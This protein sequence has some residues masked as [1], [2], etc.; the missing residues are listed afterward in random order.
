MSANQV[1]DII[2]L[3]RRTARNIGQALADIAEELIARQQHRQNQL[4]PV[5]E[6]IPVRNSGPSSTNPFLNRNGSGSRRNFSTF[7]NSTK[8]SA[9]NNLKSTKFLNL[10]KIFFSN[11]FLYGSNLRNSMNIRNFTTNSNV[12]SL[13]S[14]ARNFQKFPKIT[15]NVRNVMWNVSPFRTSTRTCFIANGSGGPGSFLYKNFVRHN[16]RLFSTYGPSFT[17]QAAN[18]LTNGVRAMIYNTY[19]DLKKGKKLYHTKNIG[20]MN[21]SKRHVSENYRLASTN[22][23]IDSKLLPSAN[24]ENDFVNTGCVVEFSLNP[25]TSS[26]CQFPTIAILDDDVMEDLENIFINHRQLVIKEIKLI[27]ENLGETIIE[28]FTNENGEPC[29]RLRFPNCDVEKMETLLLDLGVS[30]GVV[31]PDEDNDNQLKQLEQLE[32]MKQEEI[33][34]NLVENNE[35]LSSTHVSTVENSSGS[36]TNYHSILSSSNY[37]NVETNDRDEWFEINSNISVPDLVSDDNHHH[38]HSHEN[39]SNH[40][41]SDHNNE[42]DNI[43]SSEMN[44]ILSSSFSENESDSTDYNSS[45]NEIDYFQ[46]LSSGSE[47]ENEIDFNI[48]ISNDLYQYEFDNTMNVNNDLFEHY[49]NLA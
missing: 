17:H 47:N 36:E 7:T 35:I 26:N 30:L 39:E 42:N 27:K 38:H 37:A 46:V 11:K 40:I 18:N 6:R 12:S 31:K 13:K 24:V 10:F 9:R 22:S 25:S 4:Q 16:Q 28:T 29:I 45:F 3:S 23:I 14:S 41:S 44:S 34:Q 48:Q 32:T 21:I 15:S 2:N 43:E 5:L 1:R 19:D 20:S 8:N 33:Q 49:G